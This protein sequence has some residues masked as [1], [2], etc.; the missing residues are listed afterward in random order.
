ML[1]KIKRLHPDAVIPKYAK[2]GDA[3]MDLYAVEDGDTSKDDGLA[4]YSTG[5]AVE[6]P[7]GYVGL[8]FPRSSISKTGCRLSNA[9]G[10]IDSGYRGEIK[11]KMDLAIGLL[12]AFLEGDDEMILRTPPYR[13]GERVAQLIIMPYPQVEFEEVED[14]TETERGEGGFGST[15]FNKVEVKKSLYKEKPLAVRGNDLRT[16]GDLSYHCF[17]KDGTKINFLIPE[18][19]AEGL[20]LELQAQLLIRWMLTK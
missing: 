8:L 20:P 9:V 15:N 17:L 3:G 1:V 11:V 6:I 19:E 12:A 16:N 13:K 7:E 2:D 4:E 10:V 5:I 14:L 18:N